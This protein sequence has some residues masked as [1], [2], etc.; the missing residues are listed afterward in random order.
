MINVEQHLITRP[1]I[2]PGT[3]RASLE[4]KSWQFC[5]DAGPDGTSLCLGGQL[6]IESSEIPKIPVEELHL[7]NRHDTDRYF[8]TPTPIDERDL[9]AIAVERFAWGV[10]I[11]RES[12]PFMIY[13]LLETKRSLTLLLDIRIDEDNQ[14]IAVQAMHFYL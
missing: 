4:I 7:C 12:D 8:K 3:Y 2:E 11:V 14:A 10:I 9:G 1:L 13:E 6:T 5:Y